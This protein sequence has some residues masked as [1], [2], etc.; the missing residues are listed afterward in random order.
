MTCAT[1]RNI[2]PVSKSPRIRSAGLVARTGKRRGSY[3][4]SV[5]EGQWKETICQ[6]LAYMGS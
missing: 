6:T 1:H 2:I 3:E 4:V 5:G